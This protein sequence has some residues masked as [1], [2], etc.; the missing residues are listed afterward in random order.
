MTVHRGA[1]RGRYYCAPPQEAESFHQLFLFIWEHGVGNELAAPGG[2]GVK[3]TRE[4][5]AIALNEAASP[6][7]ID[8]WRSGARVPSDTNIRVLLAAITDKTTREPWQRALIGAAA[9]SR[10]KNRQNENGAA[11]GAHPPPVEPGSGTRHVEVVTKPTAFL[12]DPRNRLWMFGGAGVLALIGAVWM[13]VAAMNAPVDHA[14]LNVGDRFRDRFL[15][16]AH[17]TPEMIVLPRGNFV[18]G[19]LATDAGREP[20]EDRRHSVNIDYR[21][22]VGVREVTWN[23]YM[24]CVE[25]GACSGYVPNDEGWGRGDQPIINLNFNDIYAYL[26]WLNDELG[27]A[28]ER[29]DRYTLLTEAEWEYAALA[30]TQGVTFAPYA[31]GD[32]ISAELANFAASNPQGRGRPMRVGSYPANAWGL[33]DMHGNVWEWTEDCYRERHTPMPNNGRAW[34]TRSCNHRVQKGGSFADPMT[35]LRVANRRPIRPEER[36]AETGFRLVR[37]LDGDFSWHIAQERD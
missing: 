23:E 31:T 32:T 20:D 35:E 37:R 7:S 10:E 16:G 12:Q 36:H 4:T 30:G 3:W 14:K 21:M 6:R 25:A 22:A 33:Y 19:S 18:M 11:N 8:D 1:A 2:P 34:L 15:S 17:R 24:L 5:L 9:E 13:I 27:I 26:H 29:S 28:W